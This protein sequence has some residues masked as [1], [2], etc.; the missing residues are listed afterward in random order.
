MSLNDEKWILQ[1]N[2]N[3]LIHTKNW[4]LYADLFWADI[5]V[6]IAV[7]VICP[8]QEEVLVVEHGDYSILVKHAD[9][10]QK[11]DKLDEEPLFLLAHPEP[12]LPV[13]TGRRCD[14]PHTGPGPHGHPIITMVTTSRALITDQIAGLSLLKRIQS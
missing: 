6:C 3:S 8:S 10:D 5:N 1:I 2:R 9:S 13:F 7:H 4:F 11:L 12:L 14:G